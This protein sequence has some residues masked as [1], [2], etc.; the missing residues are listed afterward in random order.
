[1]CER[2]VPPS[3]LELL[4]PA[5]PRL[6]GL[7]H[8]PEEDPRLAGAAVAARQDHQSC[9]AVRGHAVSVQTL[10]GVPVHQHLVR[11]IP[12]LALAAVARLEGRASATSRVPQ[13][14]PRPSMQE[15]AVHVD[16]L[17][18]CLLGA[19]TEHHVSS[20]PGAG[21]GVQT[22]AVGGRQ[23]AHDGREAPLLVCP[24]VALERDNGCTILLAATSDV[25]ALSAGRVPDGFAKEHPLL[26]L[27][28][29]ARVQDHHC[30]VDPRENVQA[31]A[32]PE[33]YHRPTLH[34]LPLLT[35]VVAAPAENDLRVVVNALACHIQALP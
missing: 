17:L 20:A 9:I 35:L 26:I 30:A 12:S 22:L 1:M 5:T 33:V 29:V 2:G 4:P 10:S 24:V 34:Q 13:A 11:V 28:T 16:P 8:P 32:R 3:R 27:T 7:P 6:P 15:K 25:Q 18:P 31:L 14:S 23:D 19:S 21:L